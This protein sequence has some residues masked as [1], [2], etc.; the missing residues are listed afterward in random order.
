MSAPVTLP[1]DGSGSTTI[2]G[3][4]ALAFDS[5]GTPWAA[6]RFSGG[7]EGAPGLYTINISTGEAT[8]A[9]PILDEFGDPL[10]SGIV[11]LQ[12]APDGTL[13]GGTATADGGF[14]VTIDTTTGEF[15][16]LGTMSATGGTSLG[17]LAIAGDGN[18]TLIGGTGNDTF[19]FA[20]GFGND[21]I[22]DFT[23]GGGRAMT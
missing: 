5:S 14:L 7:S 16:F 22:S 9:A 11:S 21:V 10:S 6:L 1:S 2:D 18:D 12:F 20:A 3:I 8:F 15:S 4:E 23:A 17:A 19:V 13:Y